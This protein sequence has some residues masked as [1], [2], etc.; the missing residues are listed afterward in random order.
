MQTTN[1]SKQQ[2]TTH[3]LIT[4]E[5]TEENAKD[6]GGMRVALSKNIS[7]IGSQRVKSEVSFLI[8]PYSVRQ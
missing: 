5:Q 1:N 7:S 4:R 8:L 2:I 6:G 3:F